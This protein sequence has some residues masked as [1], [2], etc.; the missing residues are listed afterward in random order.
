MHKKNHFGKNSLIIIGCICAVLGA[1]DEPSVQALNKY[2]TQ[3]EVMMNNVVN[4]NTPG[5]RASRLI[6]RRQNNQL[7]S[8]VLPIINRHGSL[9]YSGDQLHFGIDGPGFFVLQG[10]AGPLFTRDG[11]FAINDNSQLVTLS[12]KIPVMGE[13]GAI[14]IPYG[15]GG[16]PKITV[17]DQGLIMQDNTIVDRLLIVDFKDD[18]TLRSLNGV[19]FKQIGNAAGVTPYEPLSHPKVRQYYYEGSNVDMAQ[20]LVLMPETSKKYD[21]NSKALQILK[22]IKTTGRELGNPQ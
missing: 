15:N 9:V 14:S 16:T 7:I 2:E 20:E 18:S 3:Y 12:G 8:E 1:T 5:Y 17:S 22:K 4:A 6:T 19:F 11:R 21:S 10:P 13:G